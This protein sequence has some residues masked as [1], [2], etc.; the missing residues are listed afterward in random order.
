MNHPYTESY[1]KN[2]NYTN[3]LDREA[4]YTKTAEDLNKLFESLTIVDKNSRI[5]D[6]GCA[7]G[8]L[9]SSL[10]NL[11]YCNV[12]GYDISDWAISKAKE[13]GCKILDKVEDTRFDLVFFLDVLE[14][15]TDAQIINLFKKNHFKIIIVRIPCSEEC[16]SR[17]FFLDI[18]KQDPTHINCKTKKEW[19]KFMKKLGY[20]HSFKLNLNTIYDSAGCFCYLF[21]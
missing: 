3:Y 15:M 20:N 17:E 19:K 13:R 10:S 1:F 7:V 4:K 9:V 6:Y 21:M 8:F 12:I 2:V 18:S 16:N 11:N 14:H 5:L